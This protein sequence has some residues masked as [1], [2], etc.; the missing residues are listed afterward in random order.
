M[1]VTDIR[2]YIWKKKKSRTP[3]LTYNHIFKQSGGTEQWITCCSCW[4]ETKFAHSRHRWPYISL[5]AL[6]LL[7]FFFFINYSLLAKQTFELERFNDSRF[8]ILSLH[9]KHFKMATGKINRY[10]WCRSRLIYS[11]PWGQASS[12]TFV[13]SGSSAMHDTRPQGPR[14]M[15][16]HFLKLW[17]KMFSLCEVKNS[18]RFCPLLRITVIKKKKN[19]PN[20]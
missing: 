14:L 5:D 18:K 17:N 10:H 6:R 15:T 1:C 20:K 19:Q 8:K 12:Q 13:F 2:L 7:F 16:L 9:L 4:M 3:G 11:D